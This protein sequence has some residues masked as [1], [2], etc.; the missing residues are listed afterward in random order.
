MEKAVILCVDDEKIILTSLKEQLRRNFHAEYFIETVESGEEA[1]EV[2]EELLEDTV[3]LPVVISDHIMPGMKGDELLKRIHLRAPGTLKILLTGQA[4]ADAVGNAVNNANLYRYIS[5][6]WE[7]TDLILTVSKALRSYFQDKKLED[8]NKE[9]ERLNLELQEY[10]TTLE[11][12]VAERTEALR[13]RL[14]QVEEANHHILE[15][16]QY[17]KMIQHS[18]LPNLGQI[19]THLPESF[20]FWHPRDIVGG[21]FFFTDFSENGAI[22]C[23]LDC[24]DHGVPGAFMTIIAA[25]G[26]RKII[27]D[28]G[29]CEPQEIL[30][31]LNSI[32]KTSLRQHTSQAISDDGLDAAVCWL[33]PQQQRL[34]FAGA[35]LP[36]YY[37]QQNELHVLNG[38]RQSIGYRRSDLE[39]NFTPHCLSLEPG[40]KFYLTTDG[41]IDQLGEETQRRF[42]T[43]HFKQLLIQHPGSID[44]NLLSSPECA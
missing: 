12:K 31:Q 5:K 38:D 43:K 16:I 14:T 1:L 17:A 29:C 26:L 39:F 19:Q 36:L 11:S 3:A 42:S 40:M 32:V 4:N 22:I 10:N 44:W 34:V 8:Q 35:R 41:F 7:E 25:S 15:S 30:K 33:Q 28:D 18:L 23:V 6:P 37:I 20:F 2:V 24:T 13:I 9:L 27:K 21:D